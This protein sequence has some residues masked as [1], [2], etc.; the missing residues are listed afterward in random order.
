MLAS[1]HQTVIAD[2][3]VTAQGAIVCRY[4]MF[5]GDMMLGPIAESLTIL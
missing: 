3:D 4:A 5:V 2:S 1:R